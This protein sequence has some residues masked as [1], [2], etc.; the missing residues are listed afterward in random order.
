VALRPDGIFQCVA[1]RPHTASTASFGSDGNTSIVIWSSTQVETET[2][3]RS[4][5]R[6]VRDNPANA[7]SATGAGGVRHPRA[8]PWRDGDGDDAPY[9]GEVLNGRYLLHRLLGTGGMGAVYEAE[10]QAE[11]RRVAIKLIHQGGSRHSVE[12]ISRF[13]REAKAAS[14][15]D[16]RHIT[17]VL[18]SG[19]DAR[20]GVPFIVMEYLLG[21][22]LEQ[23]LRRV[24]KLPPPVALRIIAQA[25]AGL[26][27]AHAAGI[28]HRDIKPGNIWLARSEG[29]PAITVKLLDFGIAKFAHSDPAGAAMTSLTRTGAVLGTPLYMSP[30]Q[31]S[32][33]KEVDHRTDIWSLG[34]VLYAAIAGRVP[35][36]HAEALGN[37]MVA[38]I[39]DPIPSVRKHAPWVP[40]EIAEITDTALQPDRDQRY[41][42]AAAL[43]DAIMQLIGDDALDDAMLGESP[44][45]NAATRHGD[46]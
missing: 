16:A 1:C 13:E 19:K 28:V 40:A 22:D 6:H 21:E 9:L 7:Y 5:P 24:G 34:I 44:A 31:A 23:L 32:G 14:A 38:I 43:R 2:A 36:D 37:L 17:R 15:I 10:D 45:A 11:Q 35:Y 30:E 42:S 18:D 8:K 12:M 27:Q 26:A 29:E 41:P 25:S 4:H 39:A 3:G 46:N 33:I 20:T